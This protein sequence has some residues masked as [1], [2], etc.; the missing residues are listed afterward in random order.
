MLKSEAKI[1]HIRTRDGE[2]IPRVLALAEGFLEAVS[3]AFTEQEFTLF[4][5]VFQQTTPLQVRELWMLVPVLK[6]V[7]MEQ[8]VARAQYEL[9][10]PSDGSHGAGNSMS[11]LRDIGKTT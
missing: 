6:L 7:L 8:V 4:L 3:Y 11:S 10:D 5:E 9:K 1:T 2:T